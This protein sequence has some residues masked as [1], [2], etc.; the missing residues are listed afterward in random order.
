MTP[1]GNGAMTRF[2]P[3]A[4]APQNRADQ[5]CPTD[6]L[7]KGEITPSILC[8]PLCKSAPAPKTYHQDKRRP[9]LQCAKCS[10][11]FVPPAYHLSKKQEKAEYDLHRNNPD[12]TGYRTFLDRL[13]SPLRQRL[14]TASRGLDFG[15]G[16]GPA[17]S[18]MFEEA[19]FP[20]AVY[21][22]FYAQ[23]PNALAGR[24][25]FI[26]ATEVVEHLYNPARDLQLLWGLLRCGGYLGIMT[27]RVLTKESFSR[28][29]YTHDPT[30][31]CFFS[32]ATFQ[33]LAD[34]LNADLEII[35]KDVILLHKRG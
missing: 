35:C 11:V 6:I 28:W 30:H 7:F 20:M 34:H 25:D 10:L 22:P 21:D 23:N 9:Y 33:W 15:C 12:D 8:C 3:I 16:P 17:L 27:K 29:H 32:L 26:T 1:C 14:P 18:M 4:P 19:G 31:V 13:F 2:T 5:T 24:Y